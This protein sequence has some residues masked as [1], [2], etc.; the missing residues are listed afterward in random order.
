M[1][2][3]HRN[4][5][6]H[7]P[8]A[9][10]GQ[11]AK[12]SHHALVEQIPAI[13]YVEDVET[14]ATLYDSSQI[15]MILGYPQDTYA[16]DPQYW[17][18]ILHPDDRERVWAAEV[19]AAEHG[20]FK[21]EYRVFASD[22]RVVWLR[23]EA[24]IVRDEEGRPQFWQGAKFDVTERKRV[25]QTLRESEERY[26][27]VA[28]ATN[29]VIWDSDLLT[30]RQTWNGAVE[31]MFG[32]PVHQVTN[33]AWW[34]EHVHPEDR[35]R[36]LSI[37][38][39]VLRGGGD[40]W[41]DEYRFQRAD[42]TYSTVVDRAYVVRNAQGEP[43]RVIGSMMDVTQRR[44]AEERLRASEAELRALFAAMTDVILVLDAQG[45]YLKI[46]PTNPSLLYR[47]PDELIGKTL[48][49][50]MP[51][52]QANMFLD[53]IRR[54]L[55]TKRPVNTEYSLQIGDEEV[56]FAGT[57]SPMQEDSVV[58]IARDIT[59]RKQSEEEIR[60]LNENLENRVAERTAQL[61]AAKQ[62]L[63]FLA[64]A[65]AMLSSSLDYRATLSS[66]AR[67]AVPTLA[68]WCAV[69]ALEEDGLL[70][71]VAVTHQDP[72]KVRW[73]YELQERY[74][75]D[76]D[77]PQ[78]VP[79]VL[80]TSLSEFYPEITDEMLVAASYDE[81]QLRMLREVGFTAA[82]VVPMVARGQSLGA[83]TLVTAESGRR[84]G[85]A[86]L[87]LAED[88]A[89]R[90][91]QAVDNAKL[92]R[93]AQREIVEREQAKEETRILNQELEQR[94]RQRTAELEQAN[95]ELEA[96][97][98]SVSHDLRGPLRSIEGFSQILLEDHAQGLDEEARGY[99]GRVRASSRRMALL[100]DDLLDLSR[101]T[102]TEMR[103][104]AVDLSAL[105]QGIAAELRKTQPERKAEFAIEGGVVANGDAR[106]LRLV[107]ENLLGNAWKFTKKEP[108]AR[109]EFGSILR[110]GDWIYYVRDNGVGFDFRY[111]DKLFEAFQ[112][113]HDPEE[114]EGTGIGLAT[115][116]RIV[117]RHGG[118]VWAEGRRGGGAT[119]YF[120]L[121]GGRNNGETGET[122]S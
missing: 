80:R 98:Y 112:R 15:E 3:N 52:E 50:V 1:V 77:A 70:E 19:E 46:A 6:D 117:H 61:E 87:E 34:E 33:N 71:R 7:K 43:V 54:A 65:S 103:R 27:L 120:S 21:L 28:R 17:S 45:R 5:T 118:T 13:I 92:H 8:A 113:L 58:Y 111:A 9:N 25:E 35:G 72:E 86:D 36:V 53:Y 101:V 63:A 109:I 95:K 100:I 107:L 116:Q 24:N 76:P 67:L 119:F 32:Y 88:L 64:E 75:P 106:L 16:K 44:R 91:A 94:V 115:V 51:A 121:L 114:F 59:E 37:I 96:F 83:I 60:R 66:V 2:F 4:A 11:Q 31:G 81:E 99:L 78:G 42:G 90:A 68:D 79:N 105:A 39:D 102:R 69:D 41:S 14:H 10:R 110:G 23:D 82:M 38:D 48:R 12:L 47:P 89:R 55:E 22:G 85:E 20:H 18:K 40:V 30:D 93:Q 84:Y 73:A 104:E 26:R 62:R 29:E 57:V 108:E 74:P 49:E 97:S 56:W 122:F